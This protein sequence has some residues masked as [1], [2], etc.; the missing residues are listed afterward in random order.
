MDEGFVAQKT[1]KINTLMKQALGNGPAS[2]YLITQ[3]DAISGT[4]Y[5]LR[6]LT[7]KKEQVEILEK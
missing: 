6:G 2:P 7:L 1:T 5:R 3:I 4:K